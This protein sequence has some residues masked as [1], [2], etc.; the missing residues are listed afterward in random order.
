MP[1]THS[2][3]LVNVLKDYC[4]QVMSQRGNV[5]RQPPASTDAGPPGTTS[6][7]GALTRSP[8]H[9]HNL[10]TALTAMS[11]L[12]LLESP[13]PHLADPITL[14]GADDAAAAAKE[15]E[16]Q[17]SAAAAGATEGKDAAQAASEL[18]AFALPL[19]TPHSLA[20]AIHTRPFPFM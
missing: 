6:P 4:S 16:G 19:A 13:L 9:A 15:Q 3:H 10:A 8:S 12:T 18:R 1:V 2:C 7:P 20:L 17:L 5:V 14:G 11:T